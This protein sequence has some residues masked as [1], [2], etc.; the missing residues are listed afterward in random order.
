M[1]TSSQGQ[2]PSKPSGLEDIVKRN[3]E[4][5]LNTPS[6]VMLTDED[7]KNRSAMIT[8][9]ILIELSRIPDCKFIVSSTVMPKNGAALHSAAA[10]VWNNKT[11]GSTSIRWENR[12]LTC[13]VHVFVLDR[14]PSNQ[15]QSNK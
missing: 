1:A 7:V 3:I 8:N 10:V 6:R 14:N 9:Y 11:D 4:F 12:F 15:S 2:Q 13:V 5:V